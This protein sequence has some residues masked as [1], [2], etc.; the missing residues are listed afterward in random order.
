MDRC[1]SWS[2]GAGA[3]IVVLSGT[4]EVVFG[5]DGSSEADRDIICWELSSARTPSAEVPLVEYGSREL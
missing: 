2:F 4:G 5:V 1:K 3:E